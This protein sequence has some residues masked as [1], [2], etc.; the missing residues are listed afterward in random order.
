MRNLFG[1]IIGFLVGT[2]L[3]VYFVS[4]SPNV[5]PQPF[6]VIWFLLDGAHQLE[7]TYSSF[8]TPGQ[9][10]V[11]LGIWIIIGAISSPFSKN[12]T[13]TVRTSFWI[14]IIVG[15]FSVASLLLNDPG[16]W[17]SPERNL[18][19]ILDYIQAILSSFVSLISAIPLVWIRKKFLREKD[20]V[21]P[22]KIETVCECG[23]VFKSKPMICAECGQSLVDSTSL[24]TDSA[25]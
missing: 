21:P 20:L 8:F 2:L 12:E 24:S 1:A 25:S 19:L 3:V 14:G 15:T 4:L 13:N 7:L 18:V 17:D 16:L 22:T 6:D 11:V 10:I 5:Y 9:G 23:A